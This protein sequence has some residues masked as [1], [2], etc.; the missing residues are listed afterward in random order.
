MSAKLTQ[1]KRR[2]R[3][4]RPA[5]VEQ[6]AAGLE[7]ICVGLRSQ[8]WLEA[9]ERHLTPTQQSIALQLRERA[10]GVSEL[11][12]RLQLSAATVS[13]AVRALEEKQ[14]L[15]KTRLADDRRALALSLTAAGEAEVARIAA[16]EAPLH[17][18]IAAL[19]AQRQGELLG[20]LIEIIA[21][22]QA[23][24]AISVSRM[25]VSC[26]HFRAAAHP[27]EPRPHHCAYIDA[28]LGPLELRA[29]CADHDPA[30]AAQAA[31]ALTQLRAPQSPEPAR[32]SAPAR[33]ARKR[34]RLRS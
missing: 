1:N 3:A 2:N 6:I 27:G 18:A 23:A 12:A 13:H 9:G 25:C 31:A 20:A 16:G 10:Q 34:T 4:T 24:G 33:A 8:A 15:T 21:A 14:L 17:R 22:L 26:R 7:R 30:P 19:P 11:A 29:H 28:P 5:A 32:S